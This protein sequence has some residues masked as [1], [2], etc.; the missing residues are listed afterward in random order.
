MIIPSKTGITLL[1]G[2]VV[3]AILGVALSALAIFTWNALIDNPRVIAQARMDYVAKS[4]VTSAQTKAKLEENR[5]KIAENI[6]KAY[7]NNLQEV[8]K[9][10]KMARDE[11]EV[12]IAE[13]EARLKSAG[14]VCFLNN[15]DIDWLRKP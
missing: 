3:G 10:T 4:E 15:S 6:S 7:S 1:T 14:R 8:L 13:Y 5:R 12:E 9:Q 2:G 11:Q